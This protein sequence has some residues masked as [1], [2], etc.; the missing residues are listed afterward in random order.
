VHL[1]LLDLVVTNPLVVLHTLRLL[2]VE[3]L[4]GHLDSFFILLTHVFI[5]DP[6]VE[7]IE[8]FKL[9]SGE[10]LHCESLSFLLF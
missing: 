5:H 8:D 1:D 4:L 6:S 3:Q 7:V 2:L 9:N 10:L